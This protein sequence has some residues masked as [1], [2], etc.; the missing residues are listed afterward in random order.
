MR[1]VTRSL[2]LVL[3]LTSALSVPLAAQRGTERHHGLWFSGG[4]GYGSAIV[5]CGDCVGAKREDGVSG[6]IAF[7]GTPNPQL[8]VGAQSVGWT[9]S[10]QGVSVT[11]GTLA[12]LAQ[13]Y[14]MREGNFFVKGGAGISGYHASGFGQTDD[15]YGFGML[16]GIGYDLPVSAKLSITPV[17]SYSA[18]WLGTVDGLTGVHQNVLQAAVA[19]TAH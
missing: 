3:A 16:G 7:G 12:F 5:T 4:L 1:N 15:H 19:L 9:K 13:W 6:F 2:G 17:L 8:L 11:L 10:E 14:P 18:G